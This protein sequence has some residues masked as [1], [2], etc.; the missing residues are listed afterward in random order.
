M[1]KRF[2]VRVSGV[3]AGVFLAFFPAGTAHPVEPARAGL[4]PP[5]HGNGCSAQMTLPSG[6][7]RVPHR[8]AS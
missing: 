2:C 4:F 6:V 8:S 3:V 7:Y 1:W 5:H